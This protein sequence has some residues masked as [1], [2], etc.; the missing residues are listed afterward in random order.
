MISMEHSNAHANDRPSWT[1]ARPILD[2][3]TPTLR[4]RH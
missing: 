4:A 3:A 2:R 1:V